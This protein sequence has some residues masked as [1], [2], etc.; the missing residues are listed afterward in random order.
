M[1][2][3]SVPLFGCVVCWSGALAAPPFLPSSCLGVLLGGRHPFPAARALPCRC[4]LRFRRS[5]LAFLALFFP[6]FF[7]CFFRG[8]SGF[9][10]GWGGFFGGWAAWGLPFF[11][12]SLLCSLV[13]CCVSFPFAIGCRS[14]AV[15][16][17]V[18]GLRLVCL[19]RFPRSRLSLPSPVGAGGRGVS[20]LRVLA[21]RP[22]WLFLVGGLGGGL[23]LCCFL[24][25]VC[26]LRW[27]CPWWRSASVVFVIFFNISR[28]CRSDTASFFMIVERKFLV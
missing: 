8:W 7:L 24:G 5:V 9:F 11:S 21:L 2:F 10:G 26:W 12:V 15:S 19:L 23:R 16:R 20:A 17:L 4:R 14:R 28:W 25:R 6:F 27:C 13:R 1:G 18:A 22:F 3:L